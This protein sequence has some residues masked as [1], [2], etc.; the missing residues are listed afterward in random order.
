M[1]AKRL[2]PRILSKTTQIFLDAS[3]FAIA[4]AAAY[5]IRFEGI[6]TSGYTRQC[7]LLAPCIVALRIYISWRM[8]IYRF[9]WRYVSLPEAI[10]I[11]R[12]IL[13]GSMILLVLRF[14][15]PPSVAFASEIHVPL[16][17]IASEYLLSLAGM[18]WLRASRRIF[19]ELSKKSGNS[20]GNIVKRVVLLGAGD[21]GN[22]LAK[23]LRGRLDVELVGFLDDDPR[24]Q[25][26]IIAGLKVFA[27]S[28]CLEQIVRQYGVDQ[29][30]ISI[31]TP[32]KSLLH[33]VVRQCKA[34]PVRVKIIPSLQEMYL[35][36]TSIGQIREVQADDLLGRDTLQTADQSESLGQMYAGRR[37]LVT[38]AGG[39]IGREIVHQLLQFRPASIVILDKD[40]NSVYELQQDLLLFGSTVPIEARVAD[41][42]C[43]PR[44]DAILSE[45]KPSIV[46]HAAA[47]K[48]V[49]M[50]EINPCEAI[51][52]NVDGTQTLLETCQKFELNKF[53]YIS[54]DKAVNP[55]NVMGA[56]KRIGELLV[57]D[58]A[59]HGTVPAACVRFGNVLG[60]R[61]SV[62]PLFQRQIAHGGPVT[63]THPEI[64]RY[65]MT[66]PEA[67]HLVLCAGNLASRGETLVLDMGNPRKILD[68]AT[69]LITLSGLRPG[70]DIEIRITG[71]RPGEKMFEELV[72]PGEILSSSPIERIS[73]IVDSNGNRF[74]S[75]A[76]RKLIQAAVDNDTSA[77]YASISNLVATFH[78]PADSTR[79]CIQTG[80]E[81]K[82]RMV[83]SP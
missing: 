58:F 38:G 68:L 10:A 64:V 28:S 24:K 65:F 17:V 20:S 82:L 4:W 60:S 49:P 26:S 43:R 83:A 37:V 12:S 62:I 22:L 15:H 52:N 55:I 5:L 25:G 29:V 51:L 48:H 3:V 59:M 47:H 80:M 21:A 13:L 14:F 8:G 50:M 39:T 27:G 53:I 34:I 35:K 66:I 11:A 16:G 63:V 19:Y 81:S 2:R 45:S 1:P 6:P 61:G 67:V 73:V 72:E 30:V 54:S 79:F 57:R 56:T 44:L 36:D 78:P 70:K 41:I 31:A 71:L 75:E 23:D 77:V 74:S 76:L 42:R 18:L 7:L 33:R 32:E 46:F 69:E 9:I 40:E